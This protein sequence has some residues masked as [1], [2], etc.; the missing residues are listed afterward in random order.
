MF[1]GDRKDP[2]QSWNHNAPKTPDKRE[3]NACTFTIVK[4]KTAINGGIF[5]Y[6]KRDF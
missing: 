5:T 6:F 4:G 3:G 2:P 1:Q